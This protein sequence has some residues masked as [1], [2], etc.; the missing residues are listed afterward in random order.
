MS[1]GVTVGAAMMTGLAARVLY[2]GHEVGNMLKEDFLSGEFERVHPDGPA[3]DQIRQMLAQKYAQNY[4]HN[5]PNMP[6]LIVQTSPGAAQSSNAPSHSP[7]Q[8]IGRSKDDNQYRS[9]SDL[10]AEAEYNDYGIGSPK[11]TDKIQETETSQ[12]YVFE[13]TPVSNPVV[14]T[15]P[16]PAPKPEAP[17]KVQQQFIFLIIL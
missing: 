4:K 7:A 8:P 1:R 16:P 9:Y 6:H 3:K 11:K 2:G 10:K 15:P 17:R 12:N 13:E 14:E 5:N